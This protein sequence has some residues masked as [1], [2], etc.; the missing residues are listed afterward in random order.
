MRSTIITCCI[1]ALTSAASNRL[2]A[3][4]SKDETAIR[5]SVEAYVTAFNKG[6]AKVDCSFMVPRC[7]LLESHDGRRSNGSQSH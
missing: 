1:I 5:A 4:Q 3:D 7:G 6:D 2:Y